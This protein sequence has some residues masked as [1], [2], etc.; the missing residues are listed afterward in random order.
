MENSKQP[1][2]PCMMQQV[3]ETSFRL[4]KEGDAKEHRMPMQG[5]TKREHFASLAM[6][7]LL[8]IF[9]ESEQNP[10]VPN[11]SNV[12]YMAEL[13]VKAADALLGALAKQ[14]DV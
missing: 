14:T 13:S 11:E 12:N 6:Q 9:Q 10:I 1:I 4:H 5:L 7:G 3:G 8:T 2:Y